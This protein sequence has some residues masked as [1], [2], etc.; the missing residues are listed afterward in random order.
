[1]DSIKGGSE[2][3]VANLSS[4]RSTNS[5]EFG[6]I[7]NSSEFVRIPALPYTSDRTIDVNSVEK[8]AGARPPFRIC[9]YFGELREGHAVLTFR[10]TAS[11][12]QL[13]WSHGMGRRAGSWI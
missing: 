12:Q 9:K 1:M 11:S 10:G 13:F 5:C 3:E 8:W 2:F 7:P 6:A 4:E